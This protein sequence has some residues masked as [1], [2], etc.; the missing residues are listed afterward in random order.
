MGVEGEVRLRR[1]QWVID[2]RGS[3]REAVCRFS[4]RNFKWWG[5]TKRVVLRKILSKVSGAGQS[6]CWVEW[7]NLLQADVDFLGGKR[8]GTDLLDMWGQKSGWGNRAM[9]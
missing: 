5:Q 4:K 7:I 1:L 6:V 2:A 9:G 8:R 3:S